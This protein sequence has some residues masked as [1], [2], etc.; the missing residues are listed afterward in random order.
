VIRPR[1]LLAGILLL[2]ALHA[3]ATAEV[4]LAVHQ[5]I[6]LT[7]VYAGDLLD[8]RGVLFTN[9]TMAWWAGNH[10]PAAD[11]PDRVEVVS[12]PAKY[13]VGDLQGGIWYQW[14]GYNE[15]DPTQIFQMMAGPRPVPLTPSPTPPTV[16][17]TPFLT[18][19]TQPDPVA[20]YLISRGG[21]F[22][23]ECSGPCQVWI[24][25]PD[26][27]LGEDA[28]NVFSLPRVSLQAGDYDLLAIYP[29]PSGTFEVFY[30]GGAI[31]STWKT[32]PS[33]PTRGLPPAMIEERL[34][35]LLADPA[36]FHGQIMEKKVRVEES[37]VDITSLGQIGPG[38]ILARG[39]TTL[40]AGANISVVFND[41]QVVLPGDRVKNTFYTL[42]KG[43]DPGAYRVW[44][45]DMKVALQDL[46]IGNHVVAAYTPGGEKTT[47]GFYVSGTFGPLE[48]PPP[49]IRYISGSP[50]I[51]TPTP[52]V[53][54]REV[55]VTVYETVYVNVT[56][57]YEEVL[58]AQ[59][60]VAATQW[61]ST[62][63][64]ILTAAGWL[65]ALAVIGYLAWRGGRYLVSVKRRA[66][67]EE[68]H[69]N[70]RRY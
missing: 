51:P 55:P 26:A 37:R 24:F 62:R 7:Q 23:F 54:E 2:T 44:E 65:G 3:A 61:A 18:P 60:E 41:D 10:D 11:L 39:L 1:V 15:K 20:D 64:E 70:D 40:P 29:D 50:F 19:V 52:E 28:R 56:P 46:P 36:H 17:G 67:T 9:L 27:I 47:V 35:A 16:E 58:R 32:V 63:T 6:P 33:V 48:T 22:T 4:V 38:E 57:P 59:A 68:Y 25:G 34:K 30:D 66:G 69:G 5:T 42:A 45:A 8:L 53:V 21:H 43:T 14:E 13:R 49:V 12:T 31:N